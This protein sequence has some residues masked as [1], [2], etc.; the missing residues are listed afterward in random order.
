MTPDHPKVNYGKTGALIIFNSLL[1]H[2]VR[3]E[4]NND[5]VS[6]A[7]NATVKELNA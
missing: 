5:R 3:C 7:Y 1:M 6:L 2:F 4:S